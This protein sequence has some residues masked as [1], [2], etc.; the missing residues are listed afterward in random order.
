MSSVGTVGVNADNFNISGNT[1]INNLTV[2]G[3]T[4]FPAN[5]IASSA[6]SGGAGGLTLTNNSANT[7]NYAP[8]TTQATGSISAANTDSSL[9]YNASTNVLTTTISGN[10]SSATQIYENYD[11]SSATQYSLLFSPSS[12]LPSNNSIYQGQAL[13]NASTNTINANVS[14]AT[15]S[16]TSTNAQI[17]GNNIQ[18]SSFYIPFVNNSNISGSY[19]LKTSSNLSVNPSTNVL[20][21]GG[22]TT[23]GNITLPTTS[24]GNY[25]ATPTTF[26]L[27]TAS[28]GGTLSGQIGYIISGAI[29]Q[30]TVSGTLFN[31]STISIPM[32]VW[33]IIATVGGKGGYGTTY[34]NGCISTVSA[35]AT[36]TLGYASGQGNNLGIGFCISQVVCIT[37][38]TPTPYYFVVQSSTSMNLVGL[39]QATRIA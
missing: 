23:T 34:V 13:Y 33:L 39:F 20:S 25:T 31:I 1:N 15:T 28:T 10:C 24:T 26:I 21:C 6:I 36:S 35:T 3:T 8:F 5:S 14:V 9:I 27:S 12:G 30:L 16:T 29:S 11:G 38:T 32:G 4:S 37:S 2:S 18:N 17:T 19:P 22:I 7:L